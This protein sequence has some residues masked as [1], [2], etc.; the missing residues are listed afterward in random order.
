MGNYRVHARASGRL[1][2]ARAPA[3]IP[4]P[5][6]GL[7]ANPEPRQ[8][9]LT[10]RVVAMVL[11]GGGFLFQAALVLGPLEGLIRY[12][13][14][15]D[16]F[17]YL[18]VARNWGLLGWPT[19]DGV[20]PTNGVQPLW[21]VLL[22]MIASFVRDGVTLLR[23][24][25]L[26]SALFS[27][28]TGVLIMK[29]GSRLAG[30]ATG[31]AATMVWAIMM[32]VPDSISVMEAPLHGLVFAALVLAA[33][34]LWER[35]PGG[36]GPAAMALFGLLLA[37]NGLCRLDGAIL[38]AM[39]GTPIFWRLLRARQWGP[40]FA[41]AAVP[42]IL[43]GGDLVINQM[44]FGSMVPIS[45]L[46][47]FF[48]VHQAHR[49]G[50]DAPWLAGLRAFGKLLQ[51]N[52]HWLSGYDQEVPSGARLDVFRMTARFTAAVVICG[53]TLALVARRASRPLA[54]LLA[55]VLVHALFLAFT[56]ERFAGN[57][58]WYF[59]P[60]RVVLAL[61]AGFGLASA[62]VRLRPRW[63]GAVLIGLGALA[64]V[65]SASWAVM[66][67]GDGDP[68]HLYIKRMR[69]ALWM[70]H[71]PEIDPDWAIGAWNAGQIG[72]FAEPREVVNL[73]GLV[74]DRAFLDDVLVTGRWKDYMRAR[75]IRY[76]VDF[77]GRD[78]AQTYAIDFNPQVSFRGIVPLAEA[79]VVKRFGPIMVIDAGPW[80]D[81]HDEETSP[82]R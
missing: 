70:A 34:A 19:F 48:Y 18:K 38:A 4:P 82:V 57:D 11:L 72:Y 20:T 1:E 76:L 69:A 56:L 40:L 15:D 59:Q 60:L 42:V 62:V 27:A 9:A 47:K 54:L 80:L 68:G 64:F 29:I 61:V 63:I 37:L 28:V 8:T 10:A 32:F 43:V 65:H 12:G 51:Q 13:T 81:L 17:L 31:A 16:T 79:H 53:W 39:I 25:G 77:N 22:A 52:L 21:G 35:G 2:G 74:Q 50:S 36:A 30:P 55:A 49:A 5:S 46:V 26:A 24:A 78:S 66:L 6:P 73:D 44:L 23:V 45:G 58:M 71:A 7:P 14:V 33:L 3:P 75:R 41:G 67:L